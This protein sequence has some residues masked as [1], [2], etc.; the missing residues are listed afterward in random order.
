MKNLWVAICWIC[1][2][3]SIFAQNFALSWNPLRT[4]DLVG[5]TFYIGGE[6]A[7]ANSNKKT[8]Q[9]SV[10]FGN[11]ENWVETS[12]PNNIIQPTTT[13]RYGLEYKYYFKEQWNGGYVSAAFEARTTHRYVD[14]WRLVCESGECFEQIFTEKRIR[15]TFNT[16]GRIG[17]FAKID[18]YLFLD[19]FTGAGIKIA[20]KEGGE[21]FLFNSLFR[22]NHNHFL[23]PAFSLG[24]RVGIFIN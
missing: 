9:V 21:G 11:W 2:T 23:H 16:M 12:I 13:F 5:P 8:L 22:L 10:G 18:N 17:Y 6:K 19:L 3:Y 7:L 20:R 4:L 1:T 15:N 24:F 14:N